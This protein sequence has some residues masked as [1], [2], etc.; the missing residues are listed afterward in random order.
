MRTMKTLNC[1]WSAMICTSNTGIRG[2]S[3][4]TCFSTAATIVLGS[5]S[6]RTTRVTPG[7]KA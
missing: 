1:R 2:A 3:A 5:P 4:R 7:R 6:L